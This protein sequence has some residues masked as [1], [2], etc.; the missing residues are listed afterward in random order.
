[1]SFTKC[2][3][4]KVEYVAHMGDDLLTVNSA[5]V[6]YD[7]ESKEWGTNDERL[8][9]YLAKNKHFSPFRHPHISFRISMPRC[10]AMQVYKHIVGIESTEV[11]CK[12]HAWNEKS[13]RYV[14]INNFYVPSVWREQHKNSKQCSGK[15]LKEQKKISEVY[16]T[17]LHQVHEAYQTLLRSGVSKEQARMILPMCSMTEVIWTASLQAIHNFLVLR[18][19]PEAQ[20]EIQN[21][22]HQIRMIAEEKFPH[23]I[24]ALEQR[25]E[26]SSS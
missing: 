10:I 4:C 24:K 7:K 12:D 17:A 3:E 20:H 1:M 15:E 9:R 13:Q 25:S 11:P 26:S 21:I 14:E 19:A 16:S 5:R 23:S 18:D 2:F 6:S 8:V 22:A